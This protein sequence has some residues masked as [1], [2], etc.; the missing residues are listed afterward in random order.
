MYGGTFNY[1]NKICD[2]HATVMN[3]N[4]EIYGAFR[5]KRTFHQFGRST[6]GLGKTVIFEILLFE[7]V[8]SHF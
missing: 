7:T 6:E 3:S 1:P 2:K 8:N 4:K 5:H